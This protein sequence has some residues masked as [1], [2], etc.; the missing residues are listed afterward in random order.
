M[1]YALVIGNSEYQDG[2]LAQLKTSITDTQALA[3]VLE[4]PKLGQF[5]E[6]STIVNPP[7]AET[8][9]S[10]SLFFAKKKPD[11]LVLLY[12]S[13]H[14]MLDDRGRLYLA[15]K[16]TRHDLLKATGISANFITDEMDSCRS[17][18]QVLILDCCYGGAFVRG[19]KGSRD[20][21]LTQGTFEGTGYGRVVLTASDSTQ[22]ALEGDQVVEQA[23]LS[24]FT[25]FLLHGLSTGEADQDG[26]G[27]I[28]L[29]E[30]YDY[31]FNKVVGQTP[32]QTPCKWSYNQQ[33]DLLIARSPRQIERKP[34]PLP[35]ELRK[36]L[37]NPYSTVRLGAVEVLRRLLDDGDP[38]NVLAAQKAL[39][40]L[41][42]DDSKSVSDAATK[43][44]ASF[45]AAQKKDEPAS[46]A[47]VSPLEAGGGPPPGPSLPPTPT[48][49]AGPLPMGETETAVQVVDQSAGTGKV[50]AGIVEASAA[51]EPEPQPLVSNSPAAA[52]SPTGRVRP[53]GGSAKLR[54]FWLIWTAGAMTGLLL[55]FGLFQLLDLYINAP[56]MSLL[57]A[58]VGIVVG[59][60]QWLALRRKVPWADWWVPGNFVFALGLGILFNLDFYMGLSGNSTLIGF[61]V[62]VALMYLLPNFIGGFLLTRG[63][64][65]SGAVTANQRDAVK[66]GEGAALLKDARFWVK[67]SAW[68]AA[69]VLVYVIL[70]QRVLLNDSD[71]KP[72]VFLTMIVLAGVTGLQQWSILSSYQ[73][74]AWVLIL[75]NLAFFALVDLATGADPTVAYI[76]LFFWLAGTIF[77]APQ[78]ALRFTGVPHEAGSTGAHPPGVWFW[79]G[80]VGS[81]FAAFV[82]GFLVTELINNLSI[83]SSP[84]NYAI[85]TGLVG[86]VLG[87]AQWRLVAGRVRGF[88]WW[89]LPNALV[90]AAVGW[91]SSPWRENQ[92]LASNIALIYMLLNL[93]TGPV[94]V[95]ITDEK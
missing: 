94:I 86:A 20:K 16:D 92:T 25:H 27:H 87:L 76:F 56:R 34:A 36:A 63:S 73:P 50:Q 8:R 74:K 75:I 19:A 95:R 12:F 44:L 45:T 79:A 3:K 24:L 42:N 46:P 31:T 78:L 6:V 37:Q 10:I 91:F 83:D 80:W 15:V 70:Y 71:F 9:R 82:F 89:I 62:M 32:L 85:G 7:E 38:S 53:A 60:I 84:T 41:S 18:R 55:W 40:L 69:P 35:L 39:E 22:F 29:D 48:E 26:D 52:E 51:M 57:L 5:D 28:S 21:A 17:R 13:C 47:S 14:G 1:R 61:R 30:L 67:W 64:N 93:A 65:L 81:M 72:F 68:A 88:W 4:D 2:T 58:L 43:A 49:I 54:N 77:L 59:A 33:G 11:D 90:L 23:N 66:P